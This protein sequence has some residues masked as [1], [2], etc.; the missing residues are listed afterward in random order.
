MLVHLEVSHH[1]QAQGVGAARHQGAGVDPALVAVLNHLGVAEKTHH[2]HCRGVEGNTTHN[3]SQMDS[4]SV[5]FQIKKRKSSGTL[6]RGHVTSF[7]CRL[8]GRFHT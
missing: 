1:H 6:K 2:H 5:H 4:L 7:Y 3:S 8:R